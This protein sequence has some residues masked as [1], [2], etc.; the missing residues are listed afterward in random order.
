M[1]EYKDQGFL[2]L[3]DESLLKESLGASPNTQYI[4]L[5]RGKFDKS[6]AVIYCRPNKAILDNWWEYAS[7]LVKYE[8][9]QQN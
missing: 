1:L 3:F 9:I 4:L 8:L 2:N 6:D 7:V 5:I